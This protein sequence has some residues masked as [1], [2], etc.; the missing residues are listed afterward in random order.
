MSS[1]R[2]RI[3]YPNSNVQ[4][5]N[6]SIADYME[7]NVTI[8]QNSAGGIAGSDTIDWGEYVGHVSQTIVRDTGHDILNSFPNTSFY[9]TISDNESL[10][11]YSIMR[12]AGYTNAFVVSS[13]SIGT[14]IVFNNG[15]YIEIYNFTDGKYVY[16]R[17]CLANG[18]VCAQTARLGM[19]SS[20]TVVQ[21]ANIPWYS[22]NP[23][24]FGFIFINTNC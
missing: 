18:T 13:A 16:L 2:V 22:G 20:N 19:S 5:R 3:I 24:T 15:N 14:K 8:P 9:F 1:Y 12:G 23:N 11:P 10:T 6:I 17:Y 21:T 7:N 4:V